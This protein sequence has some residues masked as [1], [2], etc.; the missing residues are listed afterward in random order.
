MVCKLYVNKSGVKKSSCGKMGTCPWVCAEPGTSGKVSL[1]P[2]CCGALGDSASCCKG[3]VD[4][5]P[6]RQKSCVCTLLKPWVSSPL[7]GSAAVGPRLK[8]F[9][10]PETC[11]TRNRCLNTPRASQRAR[12]SEG[13]VGASTAE[14]QPSCLL[15]SA[16]SM[17]TACAI[18]EGKRLRKGTW[19]L[20]LP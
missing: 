10:S 2:V 3:A 5:V 11:R 7:R 18:F 4:Q 12:A 6:L 19:S 8:C 1:T 20:R 13:H 16:S 17:D 9:R 14:G 15:P